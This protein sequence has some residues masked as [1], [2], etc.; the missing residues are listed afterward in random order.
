M[1]LTLEN[2]LR[3]AAAALA[4]PGITGWGLHWDGEPLPGSW[5]EVEGMDG[6][7]SKQCAHNSHDPAEA[8]Y[9]WVPPPGW[10]LYEIG[11]ERAAEETYV[12]Y[13]LLL[14]PGETFGRRP[15]HVLSLREPFGYHASLRAI[16]ADEAPEWIW[17]SF[18]DRLPPEVRM[19]LEVAQG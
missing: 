17:R 6:C 1:M 4:A 16:A 5:V 11:R 14:E 9:K 8:T 12:T 7:T 10:D 18:L 3:R 15:T 13:F 19:E 2:A